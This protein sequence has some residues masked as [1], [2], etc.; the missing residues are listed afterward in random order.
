MRAFRRPWSWDAG[1]YLLCFDRLGLDAAL[2]QAE[3][4]AKNKQLY[5]LLAIAPELRAVAEDTEVMNVAR[6][7]AQRLLRMGTK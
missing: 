1:D 5:E 4:K 6:A 7:R 3:A 2:A